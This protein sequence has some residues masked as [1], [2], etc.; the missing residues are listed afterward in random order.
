MTK[1]TH[2]DRLYDLIQAIQDHAEFDHPV[3]KFELV[4][5][6]ISYVLLTGPYAYKFKKP[7]NLGFLDFSTL[8]Q[9]R[10]YCEEEL[11]LNRR[12]APELYIDVIPVTGSE[13]HPTLGGHDPAI[14]YAVKMVQFPNGA[15]LNRVL[16][17]GRLAD[18]H[19][20]ELAMQL[21]AFHESAVTAPAADRFGSPDC[22]REQVLANFSQIRPVIQG[23]DKYSDRLNQL[24]AWTINTLEWFNPLFKERKYEG[25]VKECHGDLHLGN[26]ALHN[27]KLV[28]FD[29]IDFSQELRW[30]DVMSEAAFLIMDLHARKQPALAQRFLNAYLQTGGD[31][32]G[33]SLLRFYYIYRALVRCKVACIRLN[34]SDLTQSARDK[35]IDKYRGYLDLAYDYSLPV[36]IALIITHGLSGSGKT[37]WSQPLLENL[38][39]IR[40]RSDVERKRLH[41]LKA[42]ARTASSLG[43]GIY[44]G[45]D[46][47]QTYGRLGTL[48]KL[49][50]N[51]GYPVI[52]DATFLHASQ[53]RMFRNIALEHEVPFVILDFQADEKELRERIEKRLH[54]E[55]DAS[56][57][58]L[59]VLDSQII[60]REPLDLTE[61]HDRI[62]VDTSGQLDLPT[63]LQQINEKISSNSNLK[64]KHITL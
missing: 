32:G 30:I 3:D 43:S 40:I 9:R 36:R 2:D 18:S 49:I 46:T 20:D 62:V 23:D 8:E 14:E 21:V 61:I 35:E 16:D 28:I 63:I 19:I 7:L 24:E 37:T 34:Q 13:R 38:G 41:N 11:R 60:A 5:T 31:Y 51:A 47:A 45:E 44:S 56:E 26:I 39:A 59:N 64:N 58:D 55:F 52:A 54:G 50:L 22:I 25:C 29:C 33:L 15:E 1:A 12:L 48:A 17:A 4:E 53:R 10:F 27:G 57:A 42:G 6:H